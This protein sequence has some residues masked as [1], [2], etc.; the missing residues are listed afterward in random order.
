MNVQ[1]AAVRSY[2]PSPDITR[3]VRAM[4][5]VIPAASASVVDTRRGSRRA[6]R[7]SI[8]P[9]RYIHQRRPCVISIVTPPSIT[10]MLTITSHRA[11]ESYTT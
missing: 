11:F 5:P 1:N 4:T 7:M 6:S 10:T 2:P 3:D 9:W 8:H